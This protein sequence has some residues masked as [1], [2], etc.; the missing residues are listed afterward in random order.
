MV[1][2]LLA[3]VLATTI[4]PGAALLTVTAVGLAGALA[5]AT[6]Q[7][8][9][10]WRPHPGRSRD[11]I[12]ALRPPGMAVVLVAFMCVGVALGALNVAAAASADRHDALWLTGALP[13][14]LSLSG[15]TGSLVYG[16]WAWP[17]S[18]TA[19]LHALAALFALEWI[20]LLA[21]PPPVLALA[22]IAAPGGTFLPLL[23]V[24]YQAVTDLA[25]AGT[26]TEA[27]GWLVS[28][29]N[30]G[31]ALGTALGARINPGFHL[32]AAAALAAALTPPDPTHHQPRISLTRDDI[33]RHSTRAVTLAA[34]AVPLLGGSFVL[35]PTASAVG[36][37][38]CTANVTDQDVW[39]YTDGLR[40]RT[41][42]GTG[43]SIKG[44]LYESDRLTARCRKGTSW[45]D[46]S[47]DTKTRTGIA[48]GT[49][50]WVSASYLD[51]QTCTANARACP[52]D[53]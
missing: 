16:R 43:Y 51:F 42:P 41:G 4:S 11:L 39:P 13:A 1:G 5:V 15:I 2:P 45:Y 34:T 12:G 14:A 33:M 31:L 8:S 10:N 35:A 32:C 7:P 40:L 38:A 28:V 26:I 17:G 48:K 27:I 44:L 30:C 21:D 46:I 36:S 6:S 25:A 20:P 18:R 47:T 19:H 37:S 9:R 3:T 50:G 24:G 49:Y 53:R 23:T 29:I 22:L 52:V